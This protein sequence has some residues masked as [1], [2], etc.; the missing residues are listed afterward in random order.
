L[1]GLV[2]ELFAVDMILVTS[3]ER[4]TNWLKNPTGKLK[5]NPITPLLPGY[6][7]DKNR[8]SGELRKYS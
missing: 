1:K 5:I 6:S 7:A 8:N 3:T 4:N 2:F